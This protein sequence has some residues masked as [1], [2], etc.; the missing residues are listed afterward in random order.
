MVWQ[1]GIFYMVIDRAAKTK[2]KEGG[3]RC[4][5]KQ[6]LKYWLYAS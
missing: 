3:F 4:L 2:Y 5:E 1:N 6:W